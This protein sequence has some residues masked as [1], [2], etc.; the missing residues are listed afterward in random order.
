MKIAN[1]LLI[2]SVTLAVHTTN[3]TSIISDLDDTIKI[4]NVKSK[5]HFLNSLFGRKGFVAMPELYESLLNHKN[6]SDLYIVTASPKFISFSVKSFLKK[7]NYPPSHLIL[8]TPEYKNKLDYK[9]AVISKILSQ[10]NDETYIL[11]GDDSQ[12]DPEVYSAIQQLFPDKVEN[13]Y[14][15]SINGRNL[16]QGQI[17]FYSA[18]DIALMEYQS[19]L[20]DANDVLQIGTS[21]LESRK[22]SLVIPK[23]AECPKA[24]WLTNQVDIRLA[25]EQIHKLTLQVESKI[26]NVCQKRAL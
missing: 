18:F 24:H 21:L 10:K 11:I 19:G 14:I 22:A 23:F 26:N 4:T 1:I 9:I 3:A 17:R 2:T 5:L 16:P 6:D 12:K 25:D 20:L 7:R 8:K 13:V 15:R